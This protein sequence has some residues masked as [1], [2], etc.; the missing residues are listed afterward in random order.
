MNSS[1]KSS[2]KQEK[3]QSALCLPLPRYW[4]LVRAITES[5]AKNKWRHEQNPVGR[6][7][8]A[9]ARTRFFLRRQRRIPRFRTSFF[10]HAR[11]RL[12]I[13]WGRACHPRLDRDRS[14]VSFLGHLA[15]DHQHRNDSHYIS[16]GI[17]HSE[18]AEPRCQGNASQIRRADPRAQRRSQPA[19]RSG[20]FVR[21]GT[22]ETRKTIP[23]H[24][25][26]SRE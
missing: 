13:Y 12:G 20:K 17:P 9:R 22:K 3:N 14:D 21:R 7:K 5:H 10:R 1:A 24:A 6:I 23:K 25:Q 2:V 18:H 15:A 26:T 19:C 4:A 8:T 11:Q 16:D